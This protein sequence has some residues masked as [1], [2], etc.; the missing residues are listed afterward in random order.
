MVCSVPGF[1]SFNIFSLHCSYLLHGMTTIFWQCQK[2]SQNA[3][4]VKKI[5]MFILCIYCKMLKHVIIMPK[6]KLDPLEFVNLFQNLDK[7]VVWPR[8]K[9]PTLIDRFCCMGRGGGGS[10]LSY[11]AKRNGY[12]YHQRV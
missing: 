6:F 8:N 7:K 5:Y 4:S 12:L 11:S 1:F 10:T 3:E 2:N 9:F